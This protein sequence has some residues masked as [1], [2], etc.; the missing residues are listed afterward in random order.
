[1]RAVTTPTLPI[2]NILQWVCGGVAGLCS[3]GVGLILLLG[4]LSYAPVGQKVCNAL[5]EITWDCF[6]VYC[7]DHEFDEIRARADLLIDECPEPPMWAWM[8]E[9]LPSF[10]EWNNYPHAPRLKPESVD[11]VM[12]RYDEP[13]AP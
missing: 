4:Q 8:V 6:D 5:S 3:L 10:E 9:P 7:M 13:V 12:A 2:A 11:V 1:V